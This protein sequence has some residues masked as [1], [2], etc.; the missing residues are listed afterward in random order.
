MSEI[1]FGH[2]RRARDT[3]I[4]IFW[5]TTI[6]D[7][8]F[9]RNIRSIVLFGYDTGLGGGVIAQPAFIRD[10]GITATGKPLADIKGNIVSILQGG[11]SL[12]RTTFSR[13]ARL[14]F[15]LPRRSSVLLRCPR[16][17]PAQ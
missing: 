6:D 1:V 8:L 5:L 14:P 16:C 2:R 15:D 13:G 3:S 11:V 9:L 10:M 17:R 7:I 4:S 12:T